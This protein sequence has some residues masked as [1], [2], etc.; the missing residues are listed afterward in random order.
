MVFTDSPT[1][2]PTTYE[3]TE[4]PTSE[5][6]KSP[7]EKTHEPTLSP[8][9]S[10]PS[11]SPSRRPTQVPTFLSCT[12]QA[13]DDTRIPCPSGQF[14][15]LENGSCRAK[16]LF[17]NGVCAPIP[18]MCSQVMDPVCTCDGVT[19]SNACEAHSAHENVIS[20]GRCDTD[21]PTSSPDQSTSSPTRSPTPG[22]SPSPITPSP[23]V[24]HLMS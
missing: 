2:A 4:T 12:I 10:R 21:T 20:D 6:S 23:E 16:S 11:K 14:C 3:P 9:T 5:P 13:G 22:P 17:W 8:S 18:E 1:D 24:H 15:Q 19:Y 7:S